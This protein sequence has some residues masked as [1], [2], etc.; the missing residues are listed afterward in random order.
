MTRDVAAREAWFDLRTKEA[1]E[2]GTKA[3]TKLSAKAPVFRDDGSR[4]KHTAYVCFEKYCVSIRGEYVDALAMA[5]L[6]P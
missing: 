1:A 4:V 2:L 6:R 5:R 3:P